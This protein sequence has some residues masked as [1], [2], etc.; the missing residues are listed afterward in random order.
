MKDEA[1]TNTPRARSAATV[2]RI[3]GIK[4]GVPGLDEI[5]CGSLPRLSF[6]LIAGSPGSGKTTLALQIIFANAT[7]ARI[8][9][10][11]PSPTA[12]PNAPAPR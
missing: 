5:L 6:N 9:G 4:T 8:L 11:W 7:P 1:S 10:R 3:E 2:S 12:A